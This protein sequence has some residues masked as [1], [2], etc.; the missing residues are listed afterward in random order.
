M[1]PPVATSP[2]IIYHLIVE[3][4]CGQ[5]TWGSREN[6]AARN[7]GIL[8]HCVGPDSAA[9]GQWMRSVECQIIEGGCGDFIMISG[10]SED[11]RTSLSC[12]IHVA[13]TSSF[14]TTKRANPSLGIAADTTDGVATSNGKTSSGPEA[15]T[16][17]K[18]PPANGTRL[19]SFAKGTRSPTSSTATPLTSALAPA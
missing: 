11:T 15:G 18:S 7:S 2:T 17:S 14:T 16:T 9:G 1:S 19:K 8:L 13:P 5:K 4:K 3:F 6:K 10:K 12:E